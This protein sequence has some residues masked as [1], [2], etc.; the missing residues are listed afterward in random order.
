M[1]NVWY[2]L[3]AIVGAILGVGGVLSFFIGAMFLIMGLPSSIKEKEDSKFVLGVIGFCFIFSLCSYF[4][5][6]EIPKAHK[7]VSLQLNNIKSYEGIADIKEGKSHQDYIYFEERT[8]NDYTIL[9]LPSSQCKIHY[10]N[11]KNIIIIE[12][13]TEY[14]SLFRYLAV[15]SLDDN[16]Y[17]DIYLKDDESIK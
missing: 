4:I 9:K 8:N 10:T 14:T 16:T 2:I 13:H 7:I 12:R 1:I 15:F 6:I 17:Y 11:N 3:S 5:N